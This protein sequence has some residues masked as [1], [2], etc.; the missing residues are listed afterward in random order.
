MSRGFWF[1][2][3]A[4]SGIYA[5]AKVRRTAQA[6]TPDGIAARLAA[7][8]AGAEVFAD[9]VS[10]GMAERETELFRQLDEGTEVPRLIGTRPAE[11]VLAS[12][13]GSGAGSARVG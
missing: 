13:A 11:P 9:S 3:G 12:S 7:Y 6:F 1:L 2:A 5:L 4:A 8:R 10:K